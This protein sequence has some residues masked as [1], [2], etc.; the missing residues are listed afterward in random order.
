MRN[1]Q[2]K[3]VSNPVEFPEPGDVGTGSAANVRAILE[4]VINAT[5]IVPEG[6]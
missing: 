1:G 3:E 6:E 2:E 4:P 5:I